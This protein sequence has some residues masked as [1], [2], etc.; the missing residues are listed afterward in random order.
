[1]TAAAK[2]ALHFAA[3]P[4]GS[5]ESTAD[6]VSAINRSNGSRSPCA[7]ARAA[8]SASRVLVRAGALPNITMA[9]CAA[10]AWKRL[11]LPSTS[12]ACAWKGSAR[13]SRNA[14]MM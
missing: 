2:P 12:N 13:S 9:N 11:S 8:A 4:V 10:L 1:M 6:A 14:G 3:S 7:K 5:R